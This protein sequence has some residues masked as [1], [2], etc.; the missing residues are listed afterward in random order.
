MDAL[1]YVSSILLVLGIPALGFGVVAALV[2]PHLVNDR[3]VIKNPMSRG[4]IAKVGATT[5]IVSAISLSTLLVATEPAS[6]KAERAEREAAA[7]QARQQ[8][9]EAQEKAAEE[10]RQREAE[11]SKPVIKTETKTEAVPYES[12]ERNDNTITSG[13]RRLS[14]AGV[15]GE[16]TITY[17]VTYIRGEETARTEL[18]REISKEPI[19]QVTLVGTYVKPAPRPAASVAPQSSSSSGVVKMSRTSIC[20]APGTTY[21]NQTKNY[22]SYDS[23]SACLAAGGRMPKR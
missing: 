4:K 9:A 20:H 8:E 1:Y 5:L 15:N 22:T 6:V 7:L 3:R 10:A 2:K 17:E 19:A 13:E 14:I 16:R 11:A 21:Y 18:K 12:V 23:L